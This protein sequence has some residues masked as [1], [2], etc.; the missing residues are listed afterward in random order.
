[1][2]QQLALTL[3]VEDKSGRVFDIEMQAADMADEALPL[4]TRYYQSM[5]D[6]GTLEKGQAY[7]ELRES[8]IIFVCAFDPFG[9]GLRRYTF[10]NRCDEHLELELP[11]KAVRIF[12]N[13]EGTHG[14]ETADV[15]AFL[16][17]VNSFTATEG[18]A[19]ELAAAV[20]QLKANAEERRNY[21]TLA[22]DIQ[23]HIDKEKGGWIV[24]GEARGKAEERRE[25]ALR[26]LQRGIPIEHIAEDTGLS[27]EDVRQLHCEQ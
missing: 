10:R 24:E 9:L 2:F 22:M 17:Y 11:D 21:M 6:Q 1:M 18:Y 15:R 20:E 23:M 19:A 7:S 25:I 4:R 12:F 27:V 8:Y 26:M 5:I 3:Y 13:A 16:E 14:E